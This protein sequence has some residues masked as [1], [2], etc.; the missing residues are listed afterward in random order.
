MKRGLSG[1]QRRSQLKPSDM[2]EGPAGFDTLLSDLGITEQEAV[3]NPVVRSWVRQN[4]H[5]KY[6]PEKILSAFGMSTDVF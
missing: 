1:W 3:R 6:V 2:I 4:G 5:S